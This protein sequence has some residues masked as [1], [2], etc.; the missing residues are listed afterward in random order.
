M[1]HETKTEAM[2]EERLEEIRARILRVALVGDDKLVAYRDDI[3]ALARQ[4]VPAL[5]A[6]LEAA[7]AGQAKAEQ[8]RDEENAAHQQM[9]DGFQR[10]I[11]VLEKM[12]GDKELDAAAIA[13]RVVELEA[14]LSRLASSAA[15]GPIPFMLDGSPQSAELRLRLEFA[16]QALKP[17]APPGQASTL[18]DPKP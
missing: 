15:L 2:T 4:D 9:V 12:C 10:H 13:A 17:S 16:E 5:L 7:Q 18:Q 3:R 6:A 8:E 1:S 11:R 14:K